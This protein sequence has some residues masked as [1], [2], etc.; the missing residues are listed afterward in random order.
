LGDTVTF[1]AVI[2]GAGPKIPSGVVTFQSGSSVLGSATLDASGFATL[3]FVLPQGSYNVVAQYPGDTLFA[4]SISASIPVLVGPTV[5]FTMTSTPSTISMKSGDHTTVQ[6]DLVIA[7][8]FN[9]TLL[10]GCAGLPAYATCTFSTNSIN[11]T[12]GGKTT[13]SL[14]LDTGTPLGAGPTA[15]LHSGPSSTMCM[16]PCGVL[17]A[18]LL[19]RPRRFR[20]HLCLFG[21]I[22]SFCAIG[23]LSGCSN[24][25]NVN[26]T[27]VG[28]YTIQVIARGVASG[29]T[30]SGAILLTVTK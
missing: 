21:I 11:V 12:G 10:I 14:V 16:L 15:S 1:T 24:T 30:Q 6:I 18:L 25:F 27:P 7:P 29:Y 28:T 3:T 9:D 17:F 5:E 19:L 13:L 2:Q 23:M 20:K 22:L 4:P 8:T 26:D